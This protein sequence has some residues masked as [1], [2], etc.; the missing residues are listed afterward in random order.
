MDRSRFIAG[1]VGPTLAAMAA[2]IL[3]NG[4][5]IADM[6]RQLSQDYA[7]IFISGV[8]TLPIGLAIVSAHNV[9]RGWPVIITLFGWL[10]VIGGAVR[11]L[12]ARQLAD[13]VPGVV[14]GS[15]PMAVAAV[16]LLIGL[17]LSWKAYR[18]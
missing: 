1:L 6:A 18:R 9:W 15:A 13:A 7:L 5:M 11:I 8:I 3:V 2:S 16:L 14:A 17:F 12:F 4:G 10:A